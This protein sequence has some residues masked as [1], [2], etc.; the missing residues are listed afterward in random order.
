MCRPALEHTPDATPWPAR[1]SLRAPARSSST[2][3]PTAA[4]DVTGHAEQVD[5]ADHAEQPGQH[6]TVPIGAR[7][8]N[9][10][11]RSNSPAPV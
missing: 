8:A 3:Q 11:A 5:R 9:S 10:P 2:G 1:A 4:Q 7:Y 6:R